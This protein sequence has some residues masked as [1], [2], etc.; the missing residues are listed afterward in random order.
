LRQQASIKKKA[1]RVSAE[2]LTFLC[3]ATVA[4]W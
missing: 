2:R 4:N 1:L 3:G